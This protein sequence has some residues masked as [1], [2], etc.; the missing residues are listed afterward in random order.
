SLVG[1]SDHHQVN[2]LTLAAGRTIW[3]VMTSA[4]ADYPN[5][6]R[7]VEIWDEDNGWLTIRTVCV[8]YDNPLDPL[9]A[10]GRKLATADF[11]SGWGHDGRRDAT[12][13]NVVL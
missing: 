3:E 2:E 13:T 8:D 7:I 5:Q 12:H 9:V 6:F 10:E 11:T 4:L 1:H